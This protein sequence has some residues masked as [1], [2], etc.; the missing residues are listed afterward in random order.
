VNERT[1]VVIGIVT[2]IGIQ[3]RLIVP[4]VDVDNVVGLNILCVF[5]HQLEPHCGLIALS[6]VFYSV[7][8][9]PNLKKKTQREKHGVSQETSHTPSPLVVRDSGDLN[10]LEDFGD[11][12]P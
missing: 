9:C 4:T 8:Q 3:L 7:F 6:A 2:P 12:R 10:F 1:P 5:L 11:P